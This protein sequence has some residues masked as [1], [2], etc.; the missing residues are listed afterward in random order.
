MWVWVWVWGIGEE[1][2]SLKGSVPPSCRASTE[3]T[4]N[5][6]RKW[7][8]NVFS[9]KLLLQLWFIFYYYVIYLYTYI[10]VIR[11]C[12]WMYVKYVST[13]RPDCTANSLQIEYSMT[14]STCLVYR[15]DI[16]VNFKFHYLS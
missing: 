6:H 15:N 3:G 12:I 8:L 4:M 5:L 10:Y 9:P 16:S 11:V 1:K 14:R 7:L 13:S 2:S